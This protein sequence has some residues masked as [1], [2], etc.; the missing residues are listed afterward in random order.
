VLGQ[1]FNGFAGQDLADGF[2]SESSVSAAI[3]TLPLMPLKTFA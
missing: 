2:R 3:L 1:Q